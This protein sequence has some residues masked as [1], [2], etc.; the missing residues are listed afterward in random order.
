MKILALYGVKE[1]D[2][3][4]LVAPDA[5]IVQKCVKDVMDLPVDEKYDVVLSRHSLTLLE[6]ELVPT[7]LVRMCELVKPWG[8]VWAITPAMEWAAAQC[9]SDNP[10][11]LF[12]H[13]LFGGKEA[14]NRCGFTLEWLRNLIESQGMSIRQSTQQIWEIPFGDNKVQA[15]QN[16][17]IGWKVVMPEKGESIVPEVTYT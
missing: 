14:H 2:L 4:S 10:S 9:Y 7:V 5:E 16:V 8:E 3:S 17:V 13:L 6:P 15:L 1:Q 12:H 11:P